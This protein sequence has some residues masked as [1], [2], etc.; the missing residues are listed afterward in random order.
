MAKRKWT[1]EEVQEF[2]S[3]S[4]SI[5]YY[6]NEDSNFIV[7]KKYRFGLTFNWAN[8]ISWGIVIVVL[9]AIAIYKI[10]INKS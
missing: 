5:F 10:N 8:P 2:M 9:I 3:K 1:N 7:Y 4:G 6:N